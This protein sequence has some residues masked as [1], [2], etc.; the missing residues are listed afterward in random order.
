VLQVN[1]ASPPYWN[2]AKH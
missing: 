1:E 2:W